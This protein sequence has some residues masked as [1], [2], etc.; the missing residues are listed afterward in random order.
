MHT[1]ALYIK[2]KIFHSPRS[3]F[4]DFRGFEIT[5]IKKACFGLCLKT[6]VRPVIHMSV[7]K[8]SPSKQ[9]LSVS[10]TKGQ[11]GKRRGEG[12]QIKAPPTTAS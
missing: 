5:P 12:D 9:K 7:S 6:W 10:G 4:H 11:A 2:R 1:H 8:T 3:N